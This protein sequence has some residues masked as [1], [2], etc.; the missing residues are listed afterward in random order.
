[1]RGS[2]IRRPSLNQ[3][4]QRR[5]AQTWLWFKEWKPAGTAAALIPIRPSAKWWDWLPLFRQSPTLLG[6][7]SSLPEA[8]PTAEASRQR[9]HWV[10]VQRRSA[11]DSCAHRKRAFIRPGRRRSKAAPEDTVVSRAFSGRAGRSLSTDYVRAAISDDAPQ[12]APYPV[13]RG[14]TA[15]MRVVAVK[16][17]DVSRM[18][19]WAG[20]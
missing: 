13:Q 20:Q 19:A 6:F 11:Q 1:S 5:L 16:A 17:G 2:P 8:L 12:P 14:L 3:R 9:L 18:Q 4:Q 7:R 15:A 10:R